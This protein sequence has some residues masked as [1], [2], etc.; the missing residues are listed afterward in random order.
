M[1][2]ISRNI[3]IIL[4]EG[5]KNLKKGVINPLLRLVRRFFA[6]PYR[7]AVLVIIPFLALLF[8][9]DYHVFI[10]SK[11]VNW[12]SVIARV[13][14]IFFD[15]V[16]LGLF[17]LIFEVARGKNRKIERYREELEDI[18]FWNEKEGILKKAGVIRRLSN[19]GAKISKLSGIVLTCADVSKVNLEGA[20]LSGAK[21]NDTRLNRAVFSRHS[22]TEKRENVL[23]GETLDTRLAGAELNNAYI[24]DA[25]CAYLDF[26]G[27]QMINAKLNR[28]NLRSAVFNKTV[29]RFAEMKEALLNKADFSE[30]DLYRATFKGADLRGSFFSRNKEKQWE[31][32][33]CAQLSHTDFE[34]ANLNS[35]MMNHVDMSHA[36][37]KMAS[38]MN[39]NLKSANL[40]WVSFENA[41]LIDADFHDADMNHTI[42][43]DANLVGANLRKVKNLTLDQVRE[44]KTLYQASLDDELLKAIIKNGLNYLFKWPEE[45]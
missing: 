39:A 5:C 10:S 4:Y 25:E 28:T 13:H 21:L 41:L 37:C 11:E 42:L 19:L 18:F 43:K 33:F 12:I 44:V 27:I 15:I 6:S 31:N 17:L 7:R 32:G 38:L 9:L 40:G 26:S 30:A 2:K 22:D 35:A 8:F 20:D 36:H 16:L 23:A 24:C 45:Q 3:K 1:M 14:G 29:L 34:H